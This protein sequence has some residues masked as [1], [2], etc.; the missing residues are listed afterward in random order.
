MKLP[1]P[2]PKGKIVGTDVSAVPELVKL[3]REEAKV[4]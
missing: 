3:L 1:P 4:I 2:K